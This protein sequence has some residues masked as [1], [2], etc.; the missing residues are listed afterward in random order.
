MAERWTRVAVI[1]KGLVGARDHF[2]IRVYLAV[3][4]DRRQSTTLGPAGGTGTV[5][6][7]TGT[8]CEWSAATSNASWITVTSDFAA[9]TVTYNV[10]PYRGPAKSRN[11]TFTIAGQTF[12]VKQS[13]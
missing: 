8:G 7:T 5:T 11:G 6:V 12:S 3:W 1:T 13:K 2:G 9:G 4:I 10:E